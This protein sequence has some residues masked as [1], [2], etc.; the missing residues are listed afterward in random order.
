[1]PASAADPD[2][3]L[4][5]GNAFLGDTVL[6]IPFLRNLRRRYPR[7]TI[8]VLVEPQAAAVLADC[9]YHDAVIGWP[10][11]PRSRRF[12][13]AG[14]AK[15]GCQAGWLRARGYGRAYLLK[16]SLSSGLLAW[17]AGI[18]W[19]VGHLGDYRGGL[20]SRGIPLRPFRHQAESY[21]DLL[22]AE[23]IDVDDGHLE[24]WADPA[25]VRGSERLLSGV[26]ADR[27]RIF[28]AV[29]ST[30]ADK[31]WPTDRWAEVIDRLVREH[32][33][34]IFFCGGP[35]DLGMH[36]E[37]V[38]RLDASVAGH[39]HDH[40]RN[41]PLRQ[42]TA[43]LSRMDL[44]VGVDSGLPHIAASL[45]L[46]VVTLF[47]P[48]DPNQWHPLTAR[49][50]VLRSHRLRP[51]RPKWRRRATTPVGLR[52]EPG[53]GSMLDIGVAEVVTS[54]ARILNGDRQPPR[55]QSFD[56]R[57][58]GFRYDVRSGRVSA[59]GFPRADAVSCGSRASAPVQP[60]VMAP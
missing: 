35:A 48:T 6:A 56:L 52:W 2:R 26:A 8:D 53:D 23:G 40:T 33:C 5:V 3:I 7:A 24:N 49:G 41:V 51:Q 34:E 50:E 31:H 18:P 16:R 17:L 13:P 29:R 46:P 9:P 4:V 12:L 45:G 54:V 47:G 60:V 44:C 42:L 10:R 55:M 27:P 11:P 58:G 39:V 21:L 28:L 1:M 37:I 32:G 36:A 22:R 19:R 20:L 38:G 57:S 30:N 25:T 43:F 59:G 14:V 15:I